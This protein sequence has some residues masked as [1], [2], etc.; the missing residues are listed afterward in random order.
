MLWNGGMKKAAPEDG[1]PEMK[2]PGSGSSARASSGTQ[3]AANY[4]PGQIVSHQK[5]AF[6]AGG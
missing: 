3:F 2:C 6:A 5:A 1:F 4:G